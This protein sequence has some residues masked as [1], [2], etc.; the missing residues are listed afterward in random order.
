MK[1]GNQYTN[2]K[3]PIE[4]FCRKVTVPQD[5]TQCWIWT[6]SRL[7]YGHGAFA[8]DGRV[9][10]CTPAHRWL[11]QY[12]NGVV[13]PPHINVNHHCDNPPCVNPAHLYAGTQ[14]DNVRDMVRRG[15]ARN[16][17]ARFSAEEVRAIRRSRQSTR[18]LARA[19]GVLPNTIRLIR[20]GVSYKWI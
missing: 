4:R 20:K 12:V 7:H 18:Q 11:Y 17:R 2:T 14:A 3:T 19:W 15:R 10:R 16:G 13:L 9:P 8:P 6:G 5:A 1:Q